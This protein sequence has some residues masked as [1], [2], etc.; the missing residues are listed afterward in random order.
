VCQLSCITTQPPDQLPSYTS[1]RTPSSSPS[2]TVDTVAHTRHATRATAA[3]RPSQQRHRGV[4][5]GA[6]HTP[7]LWWVACRG[8]RCGR[9][10]FNAARRRGWRQ[11]RTLRR[12]IPRIPEIPP[13]PRFAVWRCPRSRGRTRE[14]S[15]AAVLHGARR[16]DRRAVGAAVPLLVRLGAWRSRRSLA[17]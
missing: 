17:V 3:S 6:P 12:Q 2:H 13:V 11:R 14:R 4:V 8:R 7:T 10:P 16:R 15:R 1:Y 5:A 9:V